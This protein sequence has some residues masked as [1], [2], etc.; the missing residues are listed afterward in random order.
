M[1]GDVILA[2]DGHYLYTGQEMNEEILRRKPG[3]KIA[4]RY[5]RYRTIYEATVVMGTAQ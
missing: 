2:I 3:T 1:V 4:I 5:R